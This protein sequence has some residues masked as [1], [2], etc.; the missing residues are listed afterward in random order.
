M[1]CMMTSNNVNTVLLVV[2]VI[3]SSIEGYF[4]C[5]IQRASLGW[6]VI[7]NEYDQII[8]G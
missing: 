4:S 2:L 3:F 7:C 5:I 6:C 1:L 8:V